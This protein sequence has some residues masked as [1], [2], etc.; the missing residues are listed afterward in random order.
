MGLLIVA[1]VCAGAFA[2]PSTGAATGAPAGAAPRC[3]SSQLRMRV[4]SFEGATGHRFWQL[5][6][7]NR[8]STCSLRGFSRVV[9]LARNGRRIAAK[10][11]RETGFP[12]D[13]VTVRPGHSA[14]VAFTYLDGGFCTTGN[15][16]AFRVRILLARAG[17]G[18]LLNPV[19]RNM[20]PIFLCGGSEAVYP[21]TP[22]PGP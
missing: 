15:F 6:F 16:D 4:A 9:L 19:P 20:G 14:F 1:G 11:K 21:V 17:G 12:V 18:F 5:A 22:K 13:T 8:G 3:R 7:R 10:F 2:L